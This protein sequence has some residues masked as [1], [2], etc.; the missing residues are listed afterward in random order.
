MKRLNVAIKPKTISAVIELG[1]LVSWLAGKVYAE[2][3]EDIDVN[4]AQEH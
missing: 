4:G 1:C 2:L 3:L